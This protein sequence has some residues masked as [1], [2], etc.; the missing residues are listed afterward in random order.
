MKGTTGDG[1]TWSRVVNTEFSAKIKI[2][3]SRNLKNYVVWALNRGDGGDLLTAPKEKFSQSEMIR[4]GVSSKGL[5]P[6][7]R[8]IFVSKLVTVH[9]PKPKM[10]NSEMYSDMIRDKAGSAIHDIFPDRDCIF[11]KGQ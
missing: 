11:P 10:V 1:H 7:N 5:V 2:S 8:P 3:P 9:I 6:S 4:G